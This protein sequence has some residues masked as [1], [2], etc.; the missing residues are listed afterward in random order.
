MILNPYLQFYYTKIITL[1]I[2]LNEN[3]KIKQENTKYY[4]KQKKNDR[5]YKSKNDSE[6]FAVKIRFEILNKHPYKQYYLMNHSR[7]KAVGDPR[8]NFIRLDT[9]FVHSAIRTHSID[10]AVA[11]VSI[12]FHVQIED[13]L[14]S[15]QNVFF[16]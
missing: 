8:P 16:W 1:H 4:K 5:I 7:C 15:G 11:A 3:R 14:Q 10:G 13:G 9:A 12:F 6:S 2:L